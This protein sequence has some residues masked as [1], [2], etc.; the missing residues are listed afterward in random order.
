MSIYIIIMCTRTKVDLYVTTIHTH[1][2]THTHSARFLIQNIKPVGVGVI[3]PVLGFLGLYF[4]LAFL[5]K[6]GCIDSGIVPRALSDEIAY[7]Q[8]HGDEGTL[9]NNMYIII[10]YIYIQ[11]NFRIMDALG[12]SILSIV[13][14]LSLLGGRNVWTVNGRGQAVCPL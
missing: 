4:S 13:W 1:T 3:F 11:W 7:M 2:H 8:S 14:R 6:T 10:V 9:Y 5:F 12:T